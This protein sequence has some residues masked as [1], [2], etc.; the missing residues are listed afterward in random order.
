MNV[1]FGHNPFAVGLD[2]S[3]ENSKSTGNLFV[4]QSFRNGDKDLP[5]ASANLAGLAFLVWLKRAKVSRNSTN[6][7]TT[8]NTTTATA[9]S[10]SFFIT[11]LTFCDLGFCLIRGLGPLSNY[12]H[13]TALRMP[14]ES[15]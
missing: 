7:S 5:F 10:S 9:M 14:T 2:G 3:H 12:S 8:Q 4:A 1:Q 6:G 15:E 13:E 11:L